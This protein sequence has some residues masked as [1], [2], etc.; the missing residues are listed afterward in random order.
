MP[1]DLELSAE[2]LDA[3]S[4]L[5]YAALPNVEIVEA[6]VDYNAEHG[7]NSEEEKV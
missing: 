4:V 2:E 3:L 6:V 5:A 7:E 1:E